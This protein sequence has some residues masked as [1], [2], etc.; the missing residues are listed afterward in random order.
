MK[1]DNLIYEDPCIIHRRVCGLDGNEMSRF[2][3]PI[4]NHPYRIMLLLCTW[5]TYQKIHIYVFPLPCWNL[6]FLD[7]TTRILVLVFHLLAIWTFCNKFSYVPFQAF[8]PKHFYKVMIHLCRT[9]MNGITP[10]MSFLKNPAPQVIN[11]GHKNFLLGLVK[12]Q[13]LSIPRLE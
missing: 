6:D 5:Q 9:H 7:E 4:H 3:Q 8:L 13:L 2:G 11:L 10:T 1:T 12:G